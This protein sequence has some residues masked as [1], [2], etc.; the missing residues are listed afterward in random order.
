MGWDNRVKHT[1]CA[2]LD[3]SY[4]ALASHDNGTVWWGD[5]PRVGSTS[6][7]GPNDD[8]YL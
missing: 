8:E 5:W 2:V 3:D 1:Y 4:C 7:F 6:L